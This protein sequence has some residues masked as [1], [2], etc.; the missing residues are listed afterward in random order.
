M[1]VWL[2]QLFGRRGDRSA[3]TEGKARETEDLSLTP[4]A[5]SPTSHGA[6]QQGPFLHFLELQGLDAPEESVSTPEEVAGDEALA[7]AV[8]KSFREHLPGPSS[9]PAMALQVLNAVA[10][11]D[12]SLFELS[13]LIA[14]DPAMSA[15]VL[16]VANSAAYAAPQEIETLRDAVTRLGLSEVEQ[17]GS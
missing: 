6:S 14:Q 9:L 8:M 1:W 16:R 5:S 3:A 12:V 7:A 17:V 4:P 15:E 2:E 11:H 13:R 10:D